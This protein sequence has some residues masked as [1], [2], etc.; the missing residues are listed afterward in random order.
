MK[1]LEVPLSK[2]TFFRERSRSNFVQD[3]LSETIS[4]NG[5]LLPISVRQEGSKY[6]CFMGQGRVE[7]NNRLKKDTIMAY[8]YD[9]NEKTQKEMLMDYFIDNMCRPTISQASKYETAAKLVEKGSKI[10]DVARKFGI[11]IATLKKGIIAFK[12]ATTT[13][14]Q[15]Y[16]SGIIDTEQMYGLSH[17]KDETAH[18]SVIA[19]IKAQPYSSK[20]K[21]SIVK[22]ARDMTANGEKITLNSL[23]KNIHGIN[24]ELYDLKERTDIKRNRYQMLQ[25]HISMLQ[26]DVAFVS[27]LKSEGV[28]L[29]LA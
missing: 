24:T 10:E 29:N 23:R 28:N 8:V 3:E 22:V 9:E 7:A 11:S 12:K 18:Q 5:L 6:V 21:T 1:T 17:I 26:N 14:K 2:I 20:D 16:R 19:L 27:L 25:S 13:L 4:S 15:A